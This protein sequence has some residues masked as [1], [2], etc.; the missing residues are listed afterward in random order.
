[1]RPLFHLGHEFGARNTDS[2]WLGHKSPLHWLEKAFSFTMLW[3]RS[4]IFGF[5]FLNKDGFAWD[6]FIPQ[7]PYCATKKFES[8][9]RASRIFLVRVHHHAFISWSAS[10]YFMKQQRPPLRQ[11]GCC[12][13]T[14]LVRFPF[15]CLDSIFL[16]F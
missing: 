4:L 13:C 7:F 8:E 16:N 14:F 15:I 12:S 9:I 6:S 3:R 11:P 1:M 5:G 10:P 2:V